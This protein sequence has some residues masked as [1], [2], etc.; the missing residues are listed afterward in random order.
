MSN[1][2]KIYHHHWQTGISF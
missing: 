2:L 1:L